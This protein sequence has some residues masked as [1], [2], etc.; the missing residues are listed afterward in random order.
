[1]WLVKGSRSDHRVKISGATAG[2]ACRELAQ[3]M[4]PRS[5]GGM[6]EPLGRSATARGRAAMGPGRAAS[7]DGLLGCFH[8]LMEKARTIKTP[9]ASSQAEAVEDSQDFKAKVIK[10]SLSLDSGRGSDGPPLSL[11]RAGSALS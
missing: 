8:G 9:G 5:S 6:E 1:M 3:R 7:H 10:E 2:C 4:L 11:S